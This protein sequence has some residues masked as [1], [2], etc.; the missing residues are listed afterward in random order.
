VGPG[1]INPPSTSQRVP[2]STG[3]KIPGKA[4]LARIGSTTLPSVKTTG[5]PVF[6]F[7]ATTAM[8][9]R[10]FSKVCDTKTRSIKSASR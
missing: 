1:A 8:G 3:S 4:Q 5:S 9:M 2:I 10:K 6:K 7:V